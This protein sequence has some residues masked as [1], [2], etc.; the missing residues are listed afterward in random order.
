MLFQT[1][2]RSLLRLAV[3][4]SPE[5]V[6]EAVSLLCETYWPAV[7]AFV[8]LRGHSP[9]DAEDLTQSYFAVFLEKRYLR[10]FR[11]EVGRFRTFLRA[12]IGHFLANE[13][14]RGR[15]KKRGGGRAPIALDAATAEERL[16]LEPVDRLT[17]ER[18]FERQWAAAVLSRCL[19]RLRTEQAAGGGEQRFE[20]LKAYLSSDGADAAYATLA[21]ELDLSESAVRVAVHR[22][23]RRFCAVLREEVLQTVSDPREV[24]GEIRWLLD[25]V[26]GDGKQDAWPRRR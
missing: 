1:T 16:R 23:R 18:A 13:W 7:Y 10:D 17:P 8:R 11:P 2:N 15:A 3:A 22:L 21:A 24:D 20:K 26:R 19:E 9:A 12:S 25:A 5:E 14:D 6:R 4:G